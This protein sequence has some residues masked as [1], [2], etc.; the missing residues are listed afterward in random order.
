[1]TE[2]CSMKAIMCWICFCT[3]LSES[4]IFKLFYLSSEDH[5]KSFS[6]AFES[7]LT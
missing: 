1:M 2:T 6:G 7:T 5:T 3:S 4:A